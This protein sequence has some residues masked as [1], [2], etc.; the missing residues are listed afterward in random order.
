MESANATLFLQGTNDGD[1]LGQEVLHLQCAGAK[2][3][4]AS[5]L[6]PAIQFKAYGTGN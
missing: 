2:F 1:G 5:Q 4:V 3:Y 6:P